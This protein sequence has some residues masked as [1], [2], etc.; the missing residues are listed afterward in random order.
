MDS[1][2]EGDKICLFGFSR[3]AYT[4]RC[5]AGMLHKVGLLPRNNT[6]QVAFAYQFYKD[7][8][9]EGWKMSADFKKTFC[10]D[11]SVYF[12]GVFD[13]VASVGF[14]PRK[15]PFS[16]TPTSR[17]G[18]FRHAM[19]LD[20]HRSKFKACH[21]QKKGTKGQTRWEKDTA[22]LAP[23][24]DSPQ[25]NRNLIRRASTRLSA[26]QTGVNGSLS[27]AAPNGKAKGESQTTRRRCE[28]RRTK[29]QA[30]RPMS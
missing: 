25:S 18:H 22:A 9:K 1:Y 8:S 19:A 2:R 14:V 23:K 20:E 5:L 15:L 30:R 6:A 27:K 28:T 7:D 16:S 21:W 3:G 29:R 12:V 4:A 26:K 17:T 10:I 11:A 13:C 24:R